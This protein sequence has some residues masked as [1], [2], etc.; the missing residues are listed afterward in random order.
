MRIVLEGRSGVSGLN[1][2]TWGTKESR[3]Q[4]ARII[5]ELPMDE[6]SVTMRVNFYNRTGQCMS[7]SQLERDRERLKELGK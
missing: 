5:S 6:D 2:G 7:Q 3:E 1:Y 4:K